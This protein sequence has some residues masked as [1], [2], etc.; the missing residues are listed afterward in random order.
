TDNNKIT[1]NPIK[2]LKKPPPKARER[3]LTQEERKRIFDNYP[4][5]DCFRDFL[6]AMEH[7]AGRPGE[8]SAVTAADVD[9]RTGVWVLD[10]HKTEGKTG[11]PRVIILTPTMVER[12]K[13]LMGRRPEG[14]LFLNED[15]K[16]LKRNAP[17]CRLRPTRKNHK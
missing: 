9:L 11:E 12:T 3:F 14:P 15:G 8:V 2:R 5:G 6:F 16:P 1:R 10:E 4:E 13:G 17:R 7:T